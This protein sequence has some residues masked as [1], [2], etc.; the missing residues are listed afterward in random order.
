MV[1]ARWCMQRH[2]EDRDRLLDR[3]TEKDR[4]RY[5]YSV[6]SPRGVAASAPF[7]AVSESPM[8]ATILTSEGRRAWTEVGSDGEGGKSGQFN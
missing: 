3:K 2:T 6:R 4:H 7:A 5:L 1:H 8:A